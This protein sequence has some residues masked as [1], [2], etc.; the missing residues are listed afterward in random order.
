MI[1]YTRE[2]GMNSE[3]KRCVFSLSKKDE[4]TSMEYAKNWLL[5]KGEKPYYFRESKPKA[6]V[7]GSIVLFSFEAQIFGQAVVK[8]GIREVPFEEQEN[9]RR[10]GNVVYKYCMNF[11]P[12]SIEVFRF[13][14]AKKD[15]TE[16]LGINFGQLFTYLNPNQHQEILKMAS[17]M[18]S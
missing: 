5:N 12:S 8:K 7:S 4:F 6:L 16:K 2:I 10:T 3:S 15:I 17:A 14:P 1:D 11:E 13:H 9:W 18:S